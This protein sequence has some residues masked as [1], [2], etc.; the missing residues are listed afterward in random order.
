[1]SERYR[2]ENESDGSFCTA[3]SVARI[4]L[5]PKLYSRA[6]CAGNALANLVDVH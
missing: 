1:M 2:D 5:T 6:V 3:S 4:H